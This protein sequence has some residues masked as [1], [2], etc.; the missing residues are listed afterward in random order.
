MDKINM[1][2]IF[3]SIGRAAGSK[4]GIDAAVKGMLISATVIVAVVWWKF[5]RK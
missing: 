2:K 5:F 3:T 1:D 4:G